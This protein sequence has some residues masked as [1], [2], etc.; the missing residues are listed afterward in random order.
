[1]RIQA[2][3]DQQYCSTKSYQA[4]ST[5]NSAESFGDF[6]V[7]GILLEMPFRILYGFPYGI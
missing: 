3:Q 6:Q 2:D 5:R 7:V 4:V 1:M